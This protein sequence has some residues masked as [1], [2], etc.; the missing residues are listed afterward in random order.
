[1]AALIGQVTV[2]ILAQVNDSEP[3]EISTTEMPIPGT[4]V[5]GTTQDTRDGSRL[6]IKVDPFN[7]KAAVL[8][9]LRDSLK[10]ALRNI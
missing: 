5:S 10:T 1:M 8:N 7:S 4:V 3:F 2:R 6:V 9:A